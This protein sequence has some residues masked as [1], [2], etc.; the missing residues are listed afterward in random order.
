MCGNNS[1][2]GAKSTASHSV[3]AGPKSLK[4]HKSVS[5][6]TKHMTKHTFYCATEHSLGLLF[7]SLP[8]KVKTALNTRLRDF[9]IYKHTNLT[10]LGPKLR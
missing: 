9:I 3:H 1:E 10:H 2:V 5:K 7:I 8:T 6:Y 4:R